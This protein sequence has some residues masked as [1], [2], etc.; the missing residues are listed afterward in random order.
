VIASAT[1]ESWR[2]FYCVCRGAQS[3]KIGVKKTIWNLNIYSWTYVPPTAT[4]RAGLVLFDH[5]VG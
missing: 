2:F 1:D 4:S 5:N 3:A